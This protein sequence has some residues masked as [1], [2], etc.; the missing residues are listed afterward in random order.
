MLRQPLAGS[1]LPRGANAQFPWNVLFL[2]EQ[3]RR[4]SMVRGVCDLRPGIAEE[5]G[6]AFRKPLRLIPAPPQQSCRAPNVAIRIDSSA[7]DRYSVT[8]EDNFSSQIDL[9]WLKSRRTRRNPLPYVNDSR[10]PP[11]MIVNDVSRST[12]RAATNGHVLPIAHLKPVEDQMLRT[13]PQ[14]I[15]RPHQILACRSRGLLARHPPETPCVPVSDQLEF[16]LHPQLHAQAAVAAI[17][18]AQR[19]TR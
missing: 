19:G 1:E 18:P 7:V 6:F 2:D 11:R 5:C 9:P 12:T 17:P 3:Q 8:N 16:P 15:A 10:V 4:S 14:H 13:A